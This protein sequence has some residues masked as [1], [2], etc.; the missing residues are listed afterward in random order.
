M[1][2]RIESSRPHVLWREWIACLL[3]V[4]AF[5][6]LV[7][8]CGILER[9]DLAVY[10]E[11]LRLD[12]K[13][14]HP[15]IL[16]VAVDD[17]SLQALGRWPWPREL[18][19]QLLQRLA[20]AGPRAVA[21]DMLFTEAASEPGSD[22][23]LAGALG[24][25][26][27]VSPVFLPMTVRTPL[28][29][30]RTP[31]VLAPLPVLEQAVTG[32]GH[33]HV[34]LDSDSAARSLYLHEGK[35]GH[36]WP[37]LSL[38][39]AQVSD[40]N[41][42]AGGSDEPQDGTG[43]LRGSRIL[44]PF[45]GPPG[46]YKTVPYVSVLNGEVPDAALRGKTILIGLTATGI[47][48]QYPT[49][50]ST[51]S[52]LMP[53]VEINAAALDGLLRDRS[54]VP[55]GPWLQA[56]ISALVL[57]GWM[58]WLWRAGPRASLLGLLAFG[59]LAMVITTVLQVGLRWWLPV[60]GW[61]LGALLAYVLWSW[62]RLA[63][64]LADLSLRADAMLPGSAQPKRDAWQQVVDALDRALQAK[65]QAE[66][67]RT[68]ALQLL[69][70]DLRAPQSAV[71]ALLRTQPPHR[72]EDALLYE[73]IERQ[74]K[75]TLSLADDFVL[76]LRA[77]GEE[78]VR[79]EVDLAQLLTEV[80][81][82]AWPLAKEKGIRLTLT[83]PEFD[84]DAPGCWLCVEPRLLG[85]ALFN[86]AENAVKYSSAGS[87]TDLALVWT[88]GRVPV[89]TVSD[90]GEGIPAS[91]LPTLFERYSRL[92]QNAG[93]AGHGLGL[94]LVKTVIE[95]HGGSIEVRSAPGKGTA[96]SITFHENDGA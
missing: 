79:E 64:L 85:R 1:T 40:A 43:W 42:P 67:R 30:G 91:A 56:V 74:V 37:A 17:A 47:G 23:R 58:I 7:Q 24:L 95:R 68:E 35:A 50:F 86:L 10:D 44:I 32:L 77:E 87:H 36:R 6:G 52:G 70:H 25:M 20:A 18:H 81:E 61:M 26:K 9:V 54:L 14:A 90:Q 53:G 80:H 69:S 34:E 60:G 33:I 55:V 72:D 31:E 57:L 13:P 41:K 59:A 11:L 38:A 19:T 96:F 49:P 82:R 27:A 88:P 78:Y 15:D 3:I 89:V 51:G 8:H 83:L 29:T 5:A 73:R 48:D 12:A 75:T 76:H 28:V 39:L 62:R 2:V 92:E 66:R 71:L 65:H 46:H 84:D 93:V 94:S 22:L 21:F 45:S 16:I 63:V 4:L